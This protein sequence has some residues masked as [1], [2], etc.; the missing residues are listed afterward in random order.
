[1]CPSLKILQ[2]IPYFYPAW[3]FGGPVRVAYDISKELVE[4]GHSVTVY[5][6]DIHK[7]K[8]RV[9]SAFRKVDGVN[10]FYF[11]NLS[12]YAAKRKMFITPSLI[13]AVKDHIKSFDVVHI[14][15]NRTT[16]SPILHYFLKKNLVPYIVQAHGGLRSISG[17]RLMRLYDLFFGHDLLRDASKVIALTETEAEQYNKMGVPKERIAIVPNGIDLSGYANLPSRGAFRQKYHIDN[18]AKV[19]L[20]LGRIH[21]TKGLALLIRAYAYIVKTF[22]TE[23]TMLV[24]A[25]PDDGY[26]AEMKSLV[27]SLKISSSVIFT[28]FIDYQ[29]KIE[30]LVEA[31]VFVTPSYMGFPVTFLE[32]CA[33]EVPL[34]TTNLGDKMN[35]I[36]GNL[37]YVT[38]ATDYDLAK[39]VH[40][41]ISDDSLQKKF[42]RNCRETV[43]S[44]F[45]LSTVVDKLE[46]IYTDIVREML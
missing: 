41:I 18:S 31:D 26:L 17:N 5:T 42:S 1:L 29:T 38:S 44:Q 2:V 22:K 6:S 33:A 4:R 39:A 24:I 11:K 25:G 20:Y 7:E 34:V 15:G 30:A 9:D 12:L 13:S 36:E 45:S 10:V 21:R 37:G 27:D 8:T 16:Q 28:G 23:G 40:A 3:Q 19:I 32:A 35:W 43:R 14:H 46:A